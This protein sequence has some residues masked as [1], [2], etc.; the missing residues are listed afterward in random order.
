M[1]WIPF[2]DNSG[3]P[4]SSPG[5]VTFSLEKNNSGWM[6]QLLCRESHRLQLQWQVRE[7]YGCWTAPPIMWIWAMVSSLDSTPGA[8]LR[9]PQAGPWPIHQI[10]VPN[11]HNKTWKTYPWAVLF[12]KCVGPRFDH[13]TLQTLSPPSPTSCLGVCET[14]GPWSLF[15][16]GI[17]KRLSA[18]RRSCAWSPESVALPSAAWLTTSWRT[19]SRPENLI[20]SVFL[21]PIESMISWGC[22]Q[23]KHGVPW[24]HWA[25]LCRWTG[26]AH[27]P[28]W[29]T[30][31]RWYRTRRSTL[32]S[33]R[34][35]MTPLRW[36]IWNRR[37][38]AQCFT[39]STPSCQSTKAAGWHGRPG[40][41]WKS[42]YIY[43]FIHVCTL[44]LSVVMCF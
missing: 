40:H 41:V 10:W 43:I 12:N 30:D 5:S 13:P 35:S 3:S 8:M 32:S 36:K 44:S 37:S 42:L 16:R 11:D 1:C 25:I 15:A 2:P 19:K 22:L 28:R 14:I 29:A 6:L 17:P 38:L 27:R 9:F 23:E 18:L 26:T 33:P 31:T 21:L 34:S 39:R 4:F 24:G 7:T 20:E